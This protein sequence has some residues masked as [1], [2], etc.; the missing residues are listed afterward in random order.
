[1]IRLT[2]IEQKITIRGQE[3][4]RL[5]IKNSSSR[6]VRLTTAGS[7]GPRGLTGGQGPQGPQGEPGA[8]PDIFDGGNF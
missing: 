7:P 6:S 3:T 2:S 8:I 5:T 4:P 1:M